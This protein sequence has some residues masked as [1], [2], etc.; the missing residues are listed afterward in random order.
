MLL[1]ADLHDTHALH[2]HALH[3]HAFHTHA[4]HNTTTAMDARRTGS[5]GRGPYVD[6]CACEPCVPQ[7][8][9]L[10]MSRHERW[11]QAR[12]MCALCVSLT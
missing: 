3:T 10:R 9:E 7:A 6:I 12:L 2:T 5:I 11:S 4:L 8:R 1:D